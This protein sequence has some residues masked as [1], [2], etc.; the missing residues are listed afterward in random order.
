MTGTVG[1][2]G[3][4]KT[5]IDA[6]AA[7]TALTPAGVGLGNVNNTSD[8]NKPV[9]TAAATA[10]GNVTVSG[11]VNSITGS[12]TAVAGVR[13]TVN[14]A[15]GAVTVTLPTPTIVGQP[16]LIER[17]DTSTANTITI[18]GT[19]RG[20]AASLTMPAIGVANEGLLFVAESLT[21]WAIEAGHK[22]KAWLDA[23]YA[24]VLEPVTANTASGTAVTLSGLG[25]NTVTLTGN[26]ALTFP[27]L[28]ATGFAKTFMVVLTQDST[29]ARTVTWPG[30]VKWAGGNAPV[31]SSVAGKVDAFTFTSVDGI[32]WLGFIASLDLR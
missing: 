4:L 3:S 12:A 20:S 7:A 29:G 25:V 15:S 8:A 28:P 26:A 24:Q 21:S 31:L 27:P 32:S 6:K 2:T 14:A 16:L 11:A 22:P 9:S 19:I 1:Y 5:L 30:T 10:I 17:A 13:N 18:T 23:L